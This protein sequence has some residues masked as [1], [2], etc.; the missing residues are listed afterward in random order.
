[1]T[2]DP[3]VLVEAAEMLEDL[4]DEIP[5]L[6]GWDHDFIEDLVI[7]W[8]EEELTKISSAQLFHLRRIHAET[9]GT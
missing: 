4:R 8:E 1:M 9:L 3:C 2:A 7:R 6:S 5:G